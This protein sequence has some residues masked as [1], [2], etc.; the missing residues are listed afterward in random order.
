MISTRG[1]VIDAY[2]LI[3]MIPFC[4]LFN[5]SSTRAQTSLLSDAFVCPTCGSLPACKHDPSSK[6]G[7][8]E[9]LEH[10]P[11]T[12][13]L[14]NH[15]DM[16]AEKRLRAGEEVFSCYEE[17]T[18]DG[19]L[20]VEWGFI[21]REQAGDGLV[22][23]PREVLDGNTVQVF[24]EILHSGLLEELPI[25]EAGESS[26][27][28]LVGPASTSQFGLFNLF[29]KGSI[30]INLIVAQY[31]GFID[32]SALLE[33]GD[34]ISSI[35]EAVR[36]IESDE[37]LNVEAELLVRAILDLLDTRLKGMYEPDLPLERVQSIR[38][39]S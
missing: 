36:Q 13:G 31:L 9:R 4:D 33:I 37:A 22:W 21:G 2:H 5:H 6:T 12:F 16:R 1:F 26:R 35:L 29:P 39:V 30:S 3:G 14:A 23:S 27:D 19:K 28:R 25:D 20:L 38:E 24:M 15:V 7:V 8:V 10:L 32:T 11:E 17:G 18:G 34:L